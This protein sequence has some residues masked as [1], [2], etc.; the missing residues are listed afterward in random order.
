MDLRQIS[1]QLVAKWILGKLDVNS[2]RNIYLDWISFVMMNSRRNFI[3]TASLTGLTMR[4][5]P[6]LSLFAAKDSLL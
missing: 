3:K 5:N 1:I 6:N 2:S 4:L